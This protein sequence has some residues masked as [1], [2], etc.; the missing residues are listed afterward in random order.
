M[1]GSSTHA[2][3]VNTLLSSFSCEWAAIS[4]PF[5]VEG[6]LSIVLTVD[7]GIGVDLLPTFYQCCSKVQ[8]Q[9]HL[10]PD[11]LGF[12]FVSAAALAVVGGVEHFLE[13]GAE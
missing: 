1:I 5:F 9:H 11:S 2:M 6:P 13:V 8:T 7:L 12:H 3:K 4:R 10:F